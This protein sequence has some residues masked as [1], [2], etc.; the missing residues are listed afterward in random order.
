MPI[1][2]RQITKAGLIMLLVLIYGAYMS[3]Y[4]FTVSE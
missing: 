4:Y 1:K 2:P 3:S